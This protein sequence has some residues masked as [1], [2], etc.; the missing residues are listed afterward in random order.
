[1]KSVLGPYMPD[2]DYA[3][4]VSLQ[5]VNKTVPQHT[6]ISCGRKPTQSVTD[7]MSVKSSPSHTSPKTGDTKTNEVARILSL[8]SFF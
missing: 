5:T 2:N 3:D 7:R 4:Q 1:M 6:C 8:Q